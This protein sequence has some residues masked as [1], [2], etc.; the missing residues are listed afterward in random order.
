MAF[1]LITILISCVF[2]LRFCGA[3][4]NPNAT[5]LNGSEYKTESVIPSLNISLSTNATETS[6]SS[7]YADVKPFNDRTKVICLIY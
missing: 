4:I 5:A 6:N 3:I 1:V 2:H 7:V